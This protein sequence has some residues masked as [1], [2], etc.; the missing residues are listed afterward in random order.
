[1]NEGG[2]EGEKE[3]KKE[4]LIEIKD[5]DRSIRINYI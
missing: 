3:K 5:N 4:T 1:V 2:K